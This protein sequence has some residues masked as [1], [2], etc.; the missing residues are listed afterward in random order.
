MNNQ[1][2]KANLYDEY[3]RQGDILQ[4]E[5]SKLKS[6]FPINMPEN[7]QKTINSNMQ[8]INELERKLLD[9]FK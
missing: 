9:L 4:R 2:E 1:N 5:N 6:E 8:K 7:E 3:V